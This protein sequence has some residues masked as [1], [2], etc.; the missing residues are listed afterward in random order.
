[1]RRKALHERRDDLPGIV[2]AERG[3]GHVGELRRI[4]GR[5]RRDVV[6]VRH[7]VHRP[8]HLPHRS[9]DFR[10]PGVPDEDDLV[11][12]LRVASGFVVH[13]THQGTG[14]VDHPKIAHAGIGLDLSGH[15]VGAEDGDGA[16]RNL[17]D[18]LDEAGALAAQRGDD[19]L[20]VDDFVPDV[21]RRAMDLQRPFDDVDRPHDPG[22]EPPRL[23]E[24][25]LQGPLGHRPSPTAVT[26][27]AAPWVQRR[28]CPG[29]PDAAGAVATPACLDAANRN[30]V[31]ATVS[32]AIY[33]RIFPGFIRFPGSRAR[34]IWRITDTPSLPCSRLRNPILP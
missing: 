5:Q 32:L 12:L 30:I 34:L 14:R 25:H 23:R 26:P 1:M 20:V 2:D 31:P 9:F 10:V 4:A 16:G 11:A 33:G 24:H 7:Q 28:A 6:Q 15:A 13:S 3:L 21:D 19:V 8:G 27:W 22:A 17:V 18:V 29:T